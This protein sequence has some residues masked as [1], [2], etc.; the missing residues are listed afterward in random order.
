V[1]FLRRWMDWMDGFPL[2]RVPLLLLVFAGISGAAVLVRSATRRD[3]D[4]TIWTFNH[5]AY[6][7][8]RGRLAGRPDRERIH[9]L[10]LGRAMTDRLSLGVMT[11]TELPNLVEVEQSEVGQ[12]LRGPL[13]KI[14][15]VD[16]TDRIRAEGWDRMCIEARFARYAVRGRI[17]GIPHDVHPVVIVYRPDILAE[18]GYRPEDLAIWK[19]W[20]TAAKAFYRPGARGTHEWRCGLGLSPVEA[21]DYLMLLWQRGGDF[22]DAD[23]NVTIDGPVAVDTLEVY[24]SLF[25]SDPPAAGPRLTHW[26]EDF[27]ALA[28]GQYLGMMLPDWMLATMRTDARTLLEGKLRCMPLP[29]WEPG[30]RRTSTAGGTMMGIP[31]DAG[32]VDAAWEMAKFLYF[33]HDVLVR[34]FRDYSMVPV[35]R[36]VF[37]DPA[38]DEPVPFFGGQRVGRLL[39]ELA[40]Q[41]P[42]VHGS[43]YTPEAFTL[44]N[45]VFA[46][47]VAGE[48]APRAALE[49]VARQL[50]ATMERD[51]LMIQA[52]A[53]EARP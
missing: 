15:F 53:A 36:T 13:E 46:K 10:N 12:F 33:D 48:I 35:R 43:P 2:G 38:F 29:A 8:F 32:N 30:G 28:R 25:R 44:L 45:A 23:G 14:P 27:A 39:T 3:Y 49:Q 50:R 52:A 11:R 51:R 16:L 9:L 1:R 40:E 19:D 41:V 26:A 37:D 21:F 17:F 5:L 42:P 18:L 31:R 24:L 34:R 4:L 20:V 6:D 7:E 22:F 47:V